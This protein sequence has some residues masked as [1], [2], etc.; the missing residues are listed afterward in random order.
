MPNQAGSARRPSPDALIEAAARQE[1]SRFRLFVGAAPGVGKTYAMLQAA[2]ARRDEG[3]EVVVG[4]VET[5]GRADTEELLEGLEVIP[6]RTVA[7]RGQTLTEM[8]LDALLAR[9]PAVAIVDELAHTNAP[10]SR[11]PKRYLDVE[12]LLD[13]GIEV[14]STVNIQHLESLNDVVAQITGV[15][16]R[17]PDSILDRADEVRL[18]DLSPEE[19]LQRLRDGKVYVPEQA[20]RAL[21]HFF[22]PEQLTALR[23]LALRETAEHVDEQMQAQRR[24]QAAPAVWPVTERLIVAIDGGPGSEALLRAARRISERRDVPWIAVFVELPGF[25]RASE[26][27]RAEVARLLRLAEEL[28]GEAVTLPGTRVAE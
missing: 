11:H 27:A 21:E 22:R 1:R 3:G 25:A 16:V 15:R 5:H 13:A 19:L 18:I 12:E 20:E 24:A 7:Y 28:G 23:E 8:D 6:R 14:W 4:V 10:G 26:P 2:Q 17:V 9:H